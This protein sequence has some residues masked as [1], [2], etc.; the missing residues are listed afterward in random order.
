MSDAAIWVEEFSTHY[1]IGPRE[2]D[3]AR[4]D[5][6]TDAFSS[7]LLFVVSVNIRNSQS[8]IRNRTCLRPL[9]HRAQAFAI[10]VC[11]APVSPPRL[12]AL[13]APSKFALRTSPFALDC[14]PCPSVPENA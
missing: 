5:V 9:L 14:P 13:G 3:K 2:R 6:I 11:R 7:L 12:A 10:P 8:E 4:R 1:R